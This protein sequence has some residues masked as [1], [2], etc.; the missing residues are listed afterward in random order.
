VQS[1][2]VLLFRRLHW[3]PLK[4]ISVHGRPHHLMQADLKWYP[5]YANG[6]IGFI[7]TGRI[8]A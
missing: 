4:E 7:T 2:N 3:R 5:P 1:R 8:A 6:A